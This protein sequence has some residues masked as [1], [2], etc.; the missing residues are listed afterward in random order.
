MRNVLWV[1]PAVACVLLA[2][3]FLTNYFIIGLFLFSIWLIRIFF[4]NHQQTFTMTM[5][6]SFFFVGI[7][8]VQQFL[9]QTILNEEMT[10][11]LVY[12]KITTVEVDGDRLTFEGEIYIEDEFERVKINHVIRSEEEKD[13]W[14]KHF[15]AEY[16]YISGELKEP[17][18]QSNFYQFDYKKYLNRQSIHWQLYSEEI[19]PVLS[20]TL[21]K[22]A[23]YW[24]EDMRHQI[25]VYIEETF[26]PKIASYLKVLFFADS[27]SMEE[28][29]LDN[30]RSIGVI[31]LF[32]ISGFH[33][34]YLVSLIRK[35]LLR[36]GVSHERTHLFILFMLPFYGILTGFGVSVFRAI[37]QTLILTLGKLAKKDIRTIDAWSLTMLLA[38]FIRPAIVYDIAFQLS[39]LLSGLFILLGYQQWLRDLHPIVHSFILSFLSGLV[40]LPILAQHFYEVSWVTAF[41][42]MLFL[43]LFSKLL[44]PGLFF[45]FLLSPILKRTGAFSLFSLVFQFFISTIE[46]F[47]TG[48]NQAFDFKLVIGHLP[49]A[50]LLLL[51][52]SIFHLIIQ[53]EKKQFPK[54]PM[55]LSLLLSLFYYQLS[56]IGYVLM[57]DVGQG[58]SIVIKEPYN[59]AVSM[60]DTGGQL[61]WGVEEEWQKRENEFTIGENIT[62]PSLQALGISTIEHLYL[63]HADID[64]TG[65]IQ[66]IGEN[67]Q[68]N[69]ILSTRAT[70]VE[71]QV[72]Q[73][74]LALPDS[75]IVELEPPDVL[76]QLINEWLI[77]YPTNSNVTNNNQSLVL[78]VKLGK[79]DWLFT[80]D[81]EVEGE[82][83]LIQKFPGL[84]ADFLK[85]GHHGSL[86]STSEAFI[87]H[88]NP[89]YALISVGENNSF[90]HPTKEV[91][92]RLDTKNIKRLSTAESGAIMVKYVKL[93]FIDYWWS[94]IETVN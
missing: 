29:I 94:K 2:L 61:K 4:L 24:F 30:Y 35:M 54:W 68:I 65:E 18:S 37:C 78:Y 21:Q 52:L 31:H 81:L 8:F 47:L 67:L 66:N 20:T 45:L 77:L 23:I 89:Q 49:I 83:E 56:P 91:V 75:K 14:Q 57:L 34:T 12:P 17:A 85:I 36:M 9:N 55:L 28:Q 87:E 70:L 59:N 76:K 41:A 38:L 5:I 33:I 16:L 79:D 40:S 11:F 72:A 26:L 53:V 86:T 51:V 32:S 43:P 27:R 19:N 44:F 50:I 42:N 64:H 39:Y 10:E 46:E 80:G 58:D 15:P 63:T 69:T 82:R 13:K 92:D 60:I 93:P 48:L 25:L 74:L 6:L 62:T 88:I 22:P 1:F 73:Q 84:R 90:G 3:T 7:L 71:E